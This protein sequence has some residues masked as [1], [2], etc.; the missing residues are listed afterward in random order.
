MNASRIL[1]APV[2]IPLRLPTGAGNPSEAPAA[3]HTRLALRR[4]L[5]SWSIAPAVLALLVALKLLT[6]SNAA[7]QA[8][9]GFFAG[10]VD[11]VLGAADRMSF[12]NVVEPHKAPFARGDGLVLAGDFDGARGQFE[13]ALAIAPPESMD[14]CQIRVNLALTLEQLGG[15]AQA[16]GQEAMA[17]DYWTRTTEVADGAPPGCFE[18][19]ADGAGD[20]ARA[21]GER[22]ERKLNPSQQPDPGQ[23]PSQSEQ[24]QAEQQRKQDQLDQRTQDNQQD[25]QESGPDGQGNVPSDGGTSNPAAKPW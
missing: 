15:K 10:S 19:P 17:K 22:A 12:L 3:R 2:G 8:V 18:P 20:K 16:A 4:R 14:S 21:A 11:V 7:V 5:V 1:G 6:M 13:Q 23:S 24:Q 25:R 9:D